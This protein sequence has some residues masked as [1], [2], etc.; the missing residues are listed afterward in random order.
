MARTAITLNNLTADGGIN[1]PAGNNIDVTN[2]MTLAFPTT[3]I[4]AP[5]MMDRLV[6]VV[7][8]TGGSSPTVTIRAGVGGGATPGP[9]FRSGLGDKVVSA[10]ASGTTY[11]GPLQSARFAQL[12][13]SVSVDFSS[14]STGTITALLLP[15]NFG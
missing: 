9:A 11:I 12:D 3:G 10:N 7:A 6:L 1:A 13:G 4:P 2:G 15:K 5:A 14:G 8:N